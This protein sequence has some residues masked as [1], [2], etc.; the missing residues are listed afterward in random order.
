M[1]K[2]SEN[3]IIY[4]GDGIEIYQ[5]YQANR[6]YIIVITI[7]YVDSGIDEMVISNEKEAADILRQIGRPDLAKL[8][9]A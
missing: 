9:E 5:E 4:S 8:L 3:K 7:A 1:N 6:G 2:K